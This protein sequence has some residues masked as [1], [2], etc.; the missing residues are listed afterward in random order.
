MTVT[1]PKAYGAGVIVAIDF[2]NKRVQ[3]ARELDAD[4]AINPKKVVLGS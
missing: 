1:T 3:L 4:Y 2:Q